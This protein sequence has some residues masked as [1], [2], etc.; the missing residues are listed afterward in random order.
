[1]NL[2]QR[3]IIFRGN[4]QGVGFRYTACIIAR[5]CDVTGYVKNLPDGDV[6]CLVEGD[7]GEIDALV[8]E[9]PGR[10]KGF[11]RST[12]DVDAPYS[13]VYENFTVRY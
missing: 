11:I 13:G 12:N 2:Q 3:I 5:G 8:A 7:R 4:V 9:I 1:M 6:E 10:M